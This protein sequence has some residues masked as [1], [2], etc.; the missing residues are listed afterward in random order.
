MN[1]RVMPPTWRTNEQSIKGVAHRHVFILVLTK[2]AL[3]TMCVNV[4]IAC[5]LYAWVSCEVRIVTF[6]L[7]C[8]SLDVKHG[9]P[10]LS[11]YSSRG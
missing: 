2:G 3:R 11:L 4:F 10:Y 1:V 6:F 7:L 5:T 8:I 9:A